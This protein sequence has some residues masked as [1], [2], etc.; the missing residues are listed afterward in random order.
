ML[1][2]EPPWPEDG[3][4]VPLSISERTISVGHATKQN[5]AGRG[6]DPTQVSEAILLCVMPSICVHVRE[7]PRWHSGQN[8]AVYCS[9]QFSAMMGLTYATTPPG[10]VILPP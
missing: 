4:A 8:G 6:E 7:H 10:G 1:A 5:L 2:L 9:G 3:K